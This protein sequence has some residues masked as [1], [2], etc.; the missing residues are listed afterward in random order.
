M[1]VAWPAVVKVGFSEEGTFWPRPDGKELAPGRSGR[2]RC[3]VSPEPDLAVSLC[4]LLEGRDP[5][6]F[7]H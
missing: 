3:R 4:K 7:L 1:R 5:C 2:T 6:R